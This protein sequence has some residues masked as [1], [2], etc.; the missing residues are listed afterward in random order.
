MQLVTKLLGRY[1]IIYVSMKYK[2]TNS[3]S[4]HGYF[5]TKKKIEKN[6]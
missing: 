3:H 5:L 1:A 4:C 2:I 6:N